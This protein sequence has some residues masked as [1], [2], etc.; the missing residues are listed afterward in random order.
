[1]MLH[2]IL[3]RGSVSQPGVIEMMTN[4]WMSDKFLTYIRS[5]VK[6]LTYLVSTFLGYV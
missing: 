1:M 2:K 4:T 6:F 3:V 5:H